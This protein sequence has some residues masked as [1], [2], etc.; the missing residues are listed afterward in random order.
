MNVHVFP[1]FLLLRGDRELR[2]TEGY[3][4]RGE[5]VRRFQEADQAALKAVAAVSVGTLKGQQQ[6]IANLIAGFRP[7]LGEAGR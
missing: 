5:L 4:G 2:R 3:P 7:L 1:T 6:N